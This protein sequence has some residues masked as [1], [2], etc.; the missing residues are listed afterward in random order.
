M[1]AGEGCAQGRLHL[2]S[3]PAHM[4]P[5][6]ARVGMGAVHGQIMK[7]TCTDF[8]LEKEEIKASSP[9]NSALKHLFQHKPQCASVLGTYICLQ[10]KTCSFKTICH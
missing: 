6:H 10:I 1:C 4:P 5:A 2:Q 9:S 8:L 7:A 3:P